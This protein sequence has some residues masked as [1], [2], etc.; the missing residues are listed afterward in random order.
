MKK[1]NVEIIYETIRENPGIKPKELDKLLG[2]KRNF[3]ANL[4][5]SL[6]SHNLLVYED[7][8]SGLFIFE[9]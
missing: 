7:D 2:K 8:D 5:P 6:D 1:D 4:L 9:E 3:A